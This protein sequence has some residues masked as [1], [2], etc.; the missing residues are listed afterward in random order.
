MNSDIQNQQRIRHGR[1]HDD[2]EKAVP[3]FEPSC[4]FHSFSF[5][6]ASFALAHQS[7]RA[8][9]AGAESRLSGMPWK[10]DV[11]WAAKT[12]EPVRRTGWLGQFRCC[13]RG[14]ERAVAITATN[15]DSHNGPVPVGHAVAIASRLI[16]FA[17]CDNFLSAASSSSQFCFSNSS[18]FE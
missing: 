16:D 8:P 6:I 3:R 14:F 5:H 15:E 12:A 2:P 10:G 11:Y 9:P 4:E 18:A 1:A 13:R 7:P 17:S